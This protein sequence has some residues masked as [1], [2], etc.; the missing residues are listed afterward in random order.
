MSTPHAASRT[1]ANPEPVSREASILGDPQFP[2]VALKQAQ[3]DEHR[4]FQAVFQTYSRLELTKETDKPTAISG[5]GH[6]LA[7]ALQSDYSF[8]V[9]TSP[10]HLHRSLLWRRAGPTLL[11]RIDENCLEVPTW[12]WTSIHGAIDYLQVES[13]EVQWNPKISLKPTT[14]IGRAAWELTAPVRDFAID[15]IWN[16]QN[17]LVLDR[18][19]TANI[20]E[21][22]CAVIGESAPSSHQEQDNICYVLVI[23]KVKT[24]EGVTEYKRDGIACIRKAHL[25]V[26]G[27]ERERCRLI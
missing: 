21:L 4:I 27:G 8:G 6:R 7:D 18:Q 5:M 24:A 22:K 26:G 13:K 12:S 15:N 11:R 2:K 25:A 20:R 17:V 3:K 23:S 16:E 10:G 19:H 9:F 14:Q 1:F